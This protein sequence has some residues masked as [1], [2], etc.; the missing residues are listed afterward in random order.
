MVGH[1]SEITTLAAAT[2]SPHEGCGSTEGRSAGRVLQR[3]PGS[4][5]R[6]RTQSH[7]SN[8]TGERQGWWCFS[9]KK[10]SSVLRFSC[11]YP[12]RISYRYLARNPAPDIIWL[13]IR[14]K[15]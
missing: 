7:Q 15:S 5:G 4:L 1:D 9:T 10:V 11:R 2:S 13:L 8:P 6:M 14:S 12:V 3:R